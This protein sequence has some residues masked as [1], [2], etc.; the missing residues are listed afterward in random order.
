MSQETPTLEEMLERLLKVGGSDLHLKVG[1]PPTYRIDGSLQRAD[2]P[3]LTADRT[4]QLL[5]AMLPAHLERPGP[6]HDIDFSWGRS[7]LGRFRV[8][9]YTQRGSVNIVVRSVPQVTERLPD[10]GL[11]QAVAKLCNAQ[12]GLIVIAGPTGAGKTTTSAAILDEINRTRPASIITIEDPIEV[13]HTD[14][15]S[16]V[17]QREVGLDIGSLAEGMQSVVRQD[18]DVVYLAEM[19]DRATIEEALVAAETGHLVI[20]TMYTMDAVETVHRILDSF[21]P[22]LERRIRQML[23]TSL[24]AI[25]AQR[26]LPSNDGSGRVPAVEL[27]LNTEATRDR[28]LGVEPMDT[29]YETIA[30]GGFYGMQTLDQAIVQLYE[31]GRVTFSDA[32]MY[33]AS[34]REFKLA[35]GSLTSMG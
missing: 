30:E 9:S 7:D 33:V 17:S 18:C 6:G 27:M 25:V 23:G 14:Q 4:E 29:L 1:S 21:P 32:L 3:S 26:L 5:E 12:S 31:A 22:Y 13:L 19:R 28:L 16:I 8:N 20:T 24:T 35:T 10:L 34:P 15:Q 11:P 2:L